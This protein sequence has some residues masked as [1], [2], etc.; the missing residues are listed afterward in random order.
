M[1]EIDEVSPGLEDGDREIKNDLEGEQ[2]LIE[3]TGQQVG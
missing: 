3:A 1:S 2:I